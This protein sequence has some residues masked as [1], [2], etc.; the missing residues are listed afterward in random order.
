RAH[1]QLANIIRS[2]AVGIT[3]ADTRGVYNHWSPSC[4][5]M[6][7]YS[8]AEVIDRKTAADFAAEP[9]DLAGALR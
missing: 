3:S 6:L 8:A 7:G 4:E 2:T 1:R 9:Y 5:A